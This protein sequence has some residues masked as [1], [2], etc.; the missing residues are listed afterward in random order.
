M[1]FSADH[2]VRRFDT[3]DEYEHHKQFDKTR[4]PLRSGISAADRAV[5]R[6]VLRSRSAAA[7]AVL[8]PLA[9]VGLWALPNAFAQDEESATEEIEVVE[10][11]LVDEDILNQAWIDPFV[12]FKLDD[13]EQASEP[14]FDFTTLHNTDIFED[15]VGN[16]GVTETFDVSTETERHL[17][18]LQAV[19]TVEN[20]LWELDQ[21][22]ESSESTIEAAT[23]EVE[24]S[25][26][27]IGNIDDE[28]A[29]AQVDIDEFVTADDAEIAIQD[30][31]WDEINEINGAVA[32]IAIQAFIGETSSPLE[33][34]LEDPESSDL[35]E[36]RVVT[37]QL[38]DLQRSD[39]DVLQEQIR[40]SDER[41][42][43][44]ADELAPFLTV[45]ADFEGQQGELQARIDELNTQRR[46][47]RIVID[48]LEDR[49][50]PL[51][52]KLDQTQTFAELTAEQYQAAYHQRLT[53]FVS[54]TNIPLVALNA[55]VR[56]ERLLATESSGCGIH[57]SQLAGIGRIESIHGYFGD[58]TLDF[59]GNTTVDVIGIPLNGRNNTIRIRDTD[60]GALDGDVF[61]DR[62]VGPMQF[63]PTTW[64]L[65]G[66]DGNAD[67]I[68]DPQNIYDAALAAARYLCAAPGSMQ[69]LSGE[70]AG[71]WAYNHDLAYS[72]NVTNAG[73]GYYDQLRIA[74]ESASFA[75]FAAQPTLEEQEAID[76]AERLAAELAAA[77]EAAAA[78]A[79]EGEA[80]EGESVGPEAAG[81]DAARTVGGG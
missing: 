6:R 59:N 10:P 32:D 78:E 4:V 30:R 48:D 17:R 79:G 12:R 31:L 80:G 2:L 21:D 25:R 81:A 76:E 62:A 56:A 74:P 68:E 75:A 15:G 40:E 57:W 58:S 41:R 7:A 45:K 23:R 34:F 43:E 37:D 33:A 9:F 49:K 69:T 13:L 19:A 38:R 5:I 11:L 36:L 77:E 60:D 26:D 1:L 24:V 65:Y 16:L 66:A 35:S 46:A 51:E 8:G 67:G 27:E 42:S 20:A 53:G 44:L 39:I 28:I 47:L 72:R 52:T 70:Q 22:I 71:Y 54:G 14:S 63:I 73:R 64:D 50:V 61:Y 3:A 55:Y 18:S 29:L